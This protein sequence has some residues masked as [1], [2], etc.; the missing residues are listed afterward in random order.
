MTE[1]RKNEYWIDELMTIEEAVKFI[2]RQR[3]KSMTLFIRVQQD[4]QIP[5]KPGYSFPI[6]G[7]VEVTARVAIKFVENAYKNFEP[8]GARV[9]VR[10]LGKCV[11]IG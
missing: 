11:F 2:K 6:S 5:T 10:G 3:G 1:E 8:R 4:G 7:N 9:H